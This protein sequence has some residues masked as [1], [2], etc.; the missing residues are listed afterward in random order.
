MTTD[1]TPVLKSEFGNS[2]HWIPTVTD[3][4]M[5]RFLKVKFPSSL[6]PARRE[7]I[8]RQTC[9]DMRQAMIMVGFRSDNKDLHDHAR[10]DCHRALYT[11][12]DKEVTFHAANWVAHNAGLVGCSIEELCKFHLDQTV[13]DVASTFDGSEPYLNVRQT[14][15]IA[16][17]TRTLAVT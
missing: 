6:A 17:K 12:A 4:E 14:N 11:Q 9:G 8:I 13:I 5:R 15:G 10:D 16:D 2:I 7:E 1:A 3:N